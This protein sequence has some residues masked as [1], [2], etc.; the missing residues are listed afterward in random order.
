MISLIHSFIH[1]YD[2]SILYLDSVSYIFISYWF[3]DLY[4]SQGKV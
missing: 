3:L 1:D 4:S 2:T